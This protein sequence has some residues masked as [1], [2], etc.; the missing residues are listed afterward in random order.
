MIIAS[1][2][3]TSITKSELAPALEAIHRLEAQCEE[4]SACVEA[5]A[6]R[7]VWPVRLADFLAA[8]DECNAACR[9]FVDAEA[10]RV[11]AARAVPFSVQVS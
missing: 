5:E 3:K 10:E 6:P 9:E 4:L 7:K 1:Q 2:R 8:F 11:C